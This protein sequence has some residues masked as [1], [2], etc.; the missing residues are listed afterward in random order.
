M[1]ASSLMEFS[2]NPDTAI[3]ECFARVPYI[4]IGAKSGWKKLPKF[5][6]RPRLGLTTPCQQPGNHLWY[7]F[8]PTVCAGLIPARG[9]DVKIAESANSL[10]IMFATI[11]N[12]FI[13]G[14]MWKPLPAALEADRCTAA[15]LLG[16]IH[17]T[18][19]GA[20]GSQLESK[21]PNCRR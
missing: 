11:R 18:L 21:F 16:W 14:A 7:S 20:S 4:H 5:Q 12:H 1:D 15:S 8:S 10:S 3:A 2:A 17:P 13:H 9:Y 19:E 6:P